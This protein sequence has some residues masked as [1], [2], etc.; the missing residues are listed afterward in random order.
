M[1]YLVPTKSFIQ[2]K[3]DTPCCLH[4]SGAPTHLPLPNPSAHVLPRTLLEVTSVQTYASRTLRV[5]M[6]I[7]SSTHA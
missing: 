1:A 6:L 4:P 3:L 2:P 5:N 7:L